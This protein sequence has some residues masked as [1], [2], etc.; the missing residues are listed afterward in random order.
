MTNK[1]NLYSPSSLF[2]APS[3]VIGLGGTGVAIIRMLKQR[4]RQS[5]HPM[6]GIIEFL[7]VDT[8][9]VQNLPGDERIFDHEIAYLGNY[10]AA[11]V[12][13]NLDRHPHI[14]EWW[15]ENNT[16][17]GTIFRGARQ[18]R[19]VGRLSLYARWGEFAQRLDRKLDKI[20]E[21]L[22]KE[23]VERRGVDVERTGQVRVYV[24][25]SLCGGTGSGIFLD[26]AFRV[27][28]KMEDIAEING[29]F[30]MPS[31]FIADI[32]SHIQQ[33]RI[34]GNTYA[35]LRELNHFL[36]GKPFYAN[37]PDR[38]VADSKRQRLS[39]PFD[40]VFLVDRG[41]GVDFLSSIESV[42]NMT[43]Q[44][45][46][47]D[48][49]TPHGKRFSS[50]RE[51]FNDL[52][53][54]RRA[55]K[56]L[57]IAGLVTASLILPADLDNKIR[58]RYACQF[59][60]R[61][62]IGDDPSKESG[63]NNDR[64]M[65]EVKS[66]I[67]KQYNQEAQNSL[68]DQI[69]EAKK[70]ILEK[71]HSKISSV[72]REFG[73]IGVIEVCKKI[74]IALKK[75]EDELTREEEILKKNRLKNLLEALVLGGKRS[76]FKSRLGFCQ[77]IREYLPEIGRRVAEVQSYAEASLRQSE[78]WLQK[79]KQEAMIAPAAKTLA[80]ADSRVFELASEVGFENEI[81]PACQQPAASAPLARY[82]E[83][84]FP[85]SEVFGDRERK[86]LD[87][88][89]Q[90]GVFNITEELIV[91]SYNGSETALYDRV[92]AEIDA[93]R[94]NVLCDEELGPIRHGVP[95]V[96]D[97]L[98]W[99]Y[100]NI[101]YHTPTIQTSRNSPIDPAR[102][103]RNRCR[104]PFI[105]IDESRL[106]TEHALDIDE[107][108]LLGTSPITSPDPSVDPDDVFVEF[109]GYY[110]ID[111]GVA[112]RFDLLF[113]RHGYKIDDLANLEEFNQAYRYF[114]DQVGETLHI[115]KNWLMD[116]LID[117]AGMRSER[118]SRSSTNPGDGRAA[119][120]TSSSMPNMSGDSESQGTTQSEAFGAG[121]AGKTPLRLK[122]LFDARTDRGLRRERNE[123]YVFAR[124]YPEKGAGVG[125][126]CYIV[127]DGLGGNSD[128]AIASQKAVTA[129]VET[130]G[131]TYQR[132]L[133][134][135]DRLT[136]E[137]MTA[138]L[139]Q[140]FAAASDAVLRERQQRQS[141]LQTT[142]VAALVSGSLAVVAN[143]GD[144]RAYLFRDGVLQRITSDHS[145]VFQ[146][147]LEGKIT[148]DQIYTHPERNVVTRSV[149]ES[150]PDP[151]DVFQQEL[152]S[153]DWLILCS[154]GLWESVRD[155]EI[156]SILG[157]CQ[158][159]GQATRRL[160]DAA[161]RVGGSDN[162]SVI[163]VHVIQ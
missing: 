110:R 71:I 40:T 150:R 118:A 3:L 148:E 113:T 141:D 23:S 100:D 107:V 73:L 15:P 46:F 83:D 76:N 85:I 11:R 120:S 25:S 104:Q 51:N 122:Q 162:I 27:R 31:V 47:L 56:T 77:T 7:A 133:Q 63:E 30:L 153:G 22:P 152:R 20:R 128:G 28:Q 138:L 36:A 33:Q 74:G 53:S 163:A 151:V 123:D 67:S 155:P 112:E 145:L 26:V 10:N 59:F 42:R 161:N 65:A 96:V 125:L 97:Y 60:E 19:L 158:E 58:S 39:R 16:I 139:R 90:L 129:V 127:A 140:A 75:R 54:E 149:G 121:G 68:D 111:T 55:N 95:G 134:S 37:F 131:Q 157:S 87:S 18:R 78:R 43:A 154:D 144:S 124:L 160:I 116:D 8:E 142:L 137:E 115:D 21:I 49:I 4:I 99:F 130:I 136:A 17:T 103:L 84:R 156:V 62:I 114:I 117:S 2:V 50:L 80:E 98:R 24:I 34:Q 29:L 92:L 64:L 88:I 48:I 66:I 82:I 109:D 57:G 5:I 135:K 108:K 91:N 119:S 32:Q 143:V 6:P 45:L 159:P 132:E 41:N 86:T 14:R 52:A 13:E 105:L 70:E 72:F 69:K 1:T 94:R 126:G 12:L 38:A 106:G 61:R 81:L 35:A 9:P 93:L 101:I 89:A 146:M 147:Y 102:Q 44:Y 79:L